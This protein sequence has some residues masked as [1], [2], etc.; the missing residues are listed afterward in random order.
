MAHEETDRTDRRKFLQAGALATASAVSLTPGLAAQELVAKTAGAP[1]AKAGQDGRRD[2]DARGRRGAGAMSAS[3][4]SPMPTASAS[5]T[6]PRSTAPSRISRSGLNKTPRSARRSSSSP[7]TCRERP[8]K[9]S[10]WSTSG[11]RLW[12][13]TTS[14]SSSSTG[15]E[16]SAPSTNRS[17]WSPARSSRKRL[18][19]SASRAR[20]SSSASR[21][22][23]RTAPRSS[24]RRP[25][26]D[27]STRSCSSIGRGSTKTRRSTRRSMSAG[28]RRSA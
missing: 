6:R 21:P 18:M 3:S 22:T 23:T 9:C 14:T 10:T 2:F 20:P 7:R 8:K 12:V 1:Q 16:T 15:W 11:W 26:R 25:K 28:R 24:R 13:P 4:G 19:R 17:T 27:S 5:S